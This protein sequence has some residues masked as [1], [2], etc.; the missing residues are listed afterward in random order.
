[1]KFSITTIALLGG[2]LPIVFSS[3][4]P[5]S[6][7]PSSRYCSRYPRRQE[8]KTSFSP[9]I[10][11]TK[12]VVTA[13]STAVATTT[14]NTSSIPVSTP[15][16][17]CSAGSLQITSFTWFNSSSN[18]DCPLA[19]DPEG[20]C[21]TGKPVQPAGYG[22]P[23]YVS[24]TVRNTFTSRSSSCIYQNPGSVPDTGEP[25]R[26]GTTKCSTGDQTFIFSFT[27][28]ASNGMGGSATAGLSVTDRFT[29]CK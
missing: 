4:F 14:P 26:A 24:F 16:A 11:S 21:F 29:N 23:D 1:M 25:G 15:P 22:P 17:D 10:S 9:V 13:T 5:Q 28:G 19:V 20:L 27:A 3:P 7:A 8:C 6:N 18:L 12:V 2:T